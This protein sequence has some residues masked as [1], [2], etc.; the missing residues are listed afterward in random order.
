MNKAFGKVQE[1]QC[2]PQCFLLFLPI[3]KH[4]GIESLHI[5]T[6]SLPI[7]LK[8]KNERM[9]GFHSLRKQAKPPP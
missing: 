2:F 5:L 3:A 1:S 8:K 7:F 4:E 6:K 9:K